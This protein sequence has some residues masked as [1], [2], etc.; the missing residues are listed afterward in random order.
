[1]LRRWRQRVMKMIKKKYLDPSDRSLQENPAGVQHPRAARCY[2]QETPL[3]S[4]VRERPGCVAQD[5]I[6]C[7]FAQ[8][9]ILR[10]A[11]VLST[12][13]PA[14]VRSGRWDGAVCQ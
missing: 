1:M 11:G 9:A 2:R 13:D 5:G 12:G 8:D 6:L 7:R 14:G 3:G 4:S 10:H